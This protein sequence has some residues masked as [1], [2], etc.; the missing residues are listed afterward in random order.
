VDLIPVCSRAGTLLTAPSM[1]CIK[2]SQSRSN[3]LKANLS[4]TYRF[5]E[6]IHDFIHILNNGVAW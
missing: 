4:D 1:C 6:Q 5:R 2:T 3:K